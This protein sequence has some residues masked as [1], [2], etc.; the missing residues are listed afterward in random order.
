MNYHLTKKPDRSKKL[1]ISIVIVFVVFFL[2]ASP[3]F[4]KPI[5]GFFVRISSSVWNFGNNTSSFFSTV[6]SFF[7]S[8][9]SLH[10]ENEMLKRELD[11]TRVEI[12]GFDVLEKENEDLK[13][14]FHRPDSNQNFVLAGILAKP[15]HSPYDILVIDAGSE[16]GIQIGSAVFSSGTPLGQVAEIYAKESKVKLFS[17]PGE[18][19]SAILNESGVSLDL[20]GLG[21][22]TFEAQIPRDVEVK[23]GD[24]VL[25]P[26]IDRKIIATVEKVVFDARDPFQKLLMRSPINFQSINFV[27][28]S[29]Q[30]SV[31]NTTN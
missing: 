4:F 1:A 18:K 9:K 10:L 24:A 26:G 25:L 3:I 28:V 19:I 14:L 30:S 13:A 8:K 16:N 11:S 15:N 29:S 2:L 6:V 5:S 21:G 27:E 17:T 7:S 23:E 12:I 20:N 22:G 31:L